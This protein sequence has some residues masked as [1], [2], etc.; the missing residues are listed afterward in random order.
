MNKTKEETMSRAE[1]NKLF[2]DIY[3]E[4]YT[5]VIGHVS[6]TIK[7]KENVKDIVSNI[8]LKIKNLNA[9]ESTRYDKDEANMKT[10]VHTITNCVIIDFVR[11]NNKFRSNVSGFEDDN[12][13]NSNDNYFVASKNDNADARILSIEMRERIEKAFQELKPQYRKIAKLYFLQDLSY[14]EIAESLNMPMGSVKGMLNRARLMLQSELKDV[15]KG[16]VINVMD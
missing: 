13:S 8:Y 4:T 3:D 14:T 15:R 1:Q 11:A 12:N 6:A 10:W 9:K 5:N 2:Q 16:K 7:C